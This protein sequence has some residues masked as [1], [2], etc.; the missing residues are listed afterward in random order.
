MQALH[1]T[2]TRAIVPVTRKL[3]Q[4]RYT[5]DNLVSSATGVDDEE[6]GSAGAQRG[7]L[8]ARR[9]GRLIPNAVLQCQKASS[10]FIE[11]NLTY[12]QVVKIPEF[13]ARER[14]YRLVSYTTSSEILWRPETGFCFV[15]DVPRRAIKAVT[16]MLSAAVLGYP[17]RLS[18]SDIDR[19]RMRKVIRFITST[20]KGGPG[21]LTRAVFRDVELNGNYFD[22]VNLRSRDLHN[23]DLYKDVQKSAGNTHAISF[24]TPIIDQIERPLA[25]RMDATGAIQ[26]YSQ[27]LS[28]KPLR[29]LLLWFE[30]ML[31]K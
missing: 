25:C 22:E 14:R 1:I 20:S 7:R 4:L 18:T 5:L 30:E 26:V 15:M 16:W 9:I 12:E 10:K 28:N 23:S 29:A 11:L 2:E 21:E 24:V 17:G 3:T 13:S 8:S 6:A 19:T 31:A 27:R